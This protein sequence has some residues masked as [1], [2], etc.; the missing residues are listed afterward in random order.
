MLQKKKTILLDLS[1]EE[2]GIRSNF[3][4]K[5]RNCLNKSEKNGLTVR[6]EQDYATF[7]QFIPL[8]NELINEKK[9]SVDLGSDFYGGVQ[10]VAPVGDKFIIMLA[11]NEGRVIAGHVASN[12]GD[13][14]VYL[15]GAADKTGREMNAAYLLQ[16]KAI[17]LGKAAGLRWYDLGGIDAEK[18]P[19][20]YTFKKRMGGQ[21]RTLPGP[22]QMK[23][24]G[25]KATLA[26]LGE[27]LYTRLKPYLARL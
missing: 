24:V 6:I 17:Q 10:K 23:P 16:W 12:L 26:E 20:V 1:L 7:L 27:K 15:L 14:C 3:H 13:T 2:A 4:Q 11:E 8:F 9:F 19:G 22:Y 21:E 25:A 18:N 5:W